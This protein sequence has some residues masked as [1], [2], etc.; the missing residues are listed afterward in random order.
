MPA[1]V[2]PVGSNETVQGSVWQ[3]SP[4]ID[5][6][7]RQG[8]ARVAVPYSPALRPGGF[9]SA[10]IVAGSTEAPLL[11]ESAVLNDARGS[12]VYVVGADNVVQRRPVRVGS[13]IDKG[14]V[15]TEGL[16]G[17]ERVVLSAGAF[18]NPG[19]KIRPQRASAR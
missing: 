14:V 9:A 17:N 11:P 6:Q 13:V 2:T 12:Y 8:E 1:T 3:V 16:S 5:P 10:A 19:D 4:I 18:L 15:I 7:S